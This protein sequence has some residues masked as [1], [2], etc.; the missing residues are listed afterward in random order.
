MENEVGDMDKWG[1]QDQLDIICPFSAAF[2]STSF[3]F[4]QCCH[5]TFFFFL[6][7][8]LAFN[9]FKGILFEDLDRKLTVINKCSMHV[10]QCHLSLKAWL[11]TQRI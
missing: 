11:S 2:I 4:L 6:K 3:Y 9:I 10:R 5:L 8:C 1:M 7:K